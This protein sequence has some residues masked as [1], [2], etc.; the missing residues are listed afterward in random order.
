MNM[1]TAEII[2]FCEERGMDFAV[3]FLPYTPQGYQW[4]ALVGRISNGRT[5]ATMDEAVRRA[6]AAYSG[7]GA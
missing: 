3:R 1:T 7:E 4:Y 5:A 6:W 2:A